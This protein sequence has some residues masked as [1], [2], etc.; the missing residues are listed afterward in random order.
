MQLESGLRIRTVERRCIQ[1]G[2]AFKILIERSGEKYER[3][4]GKT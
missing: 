4:I 2:D 3:E 1:G